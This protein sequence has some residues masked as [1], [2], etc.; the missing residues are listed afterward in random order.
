[1]QTTDLQTPALLVETTA[2]EHNLRHMAT[3]LPGKRLRPHVKAHKCTALAK[4]QRAH[5][6]A[7]FCAA[8]PLELC[9]MAAEIGRA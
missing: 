5:G 2:L 1:M 6:H 9:G 7:T 8:T 4:R 3:A